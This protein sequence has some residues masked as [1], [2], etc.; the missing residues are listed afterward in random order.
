MVSSEGW[1]GVSSKHDWSRTSK[2]MRVK[3][4][5]MQIAESL[6][7]SLLDFAILED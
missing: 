3:L 5:L 4:H 1:V 6:N 7:G 2:R